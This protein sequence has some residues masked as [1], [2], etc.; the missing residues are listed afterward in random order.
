MDDDT[1]PLPVMDYST[2]CDDSPLVD[3]PDV[4]VEDGEVVGRCSEVFPNTLEGHV[5]R[6]PCQ[7][8]HCRDGICY[9]LPP[10][11][12]IEERQDPLTVP[13]VTVLCREDELEVHGWYSAFDLS[14]N[15]RK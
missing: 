4:Q 7:R 8:I 15:K 11:S 13:G 2:P 3:L 6:G 1:L 9:S 10:W 5:P 12:L 14:K